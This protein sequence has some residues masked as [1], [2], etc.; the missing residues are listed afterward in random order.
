MTDCQNNVSDNLTLALMNHDITPFDRTGIP[1]LQYTLRTRKTRIAIFWAL[2]FFDSVA[3]PVLLY[4]ILWYGTDLDHSI[5]FTIITVC[6]GGTAIVEY[7]QRFWMLCKKNSTCRVFGGSR[8]TCDWFQWNMTM[9]FLIIISF[10][11]IGT[12]P[13][14]PMVRV[15]AMPLPALLAFYGLEMT[16]MELMYVF[17][18]R[19]PFRISSVARGQ[20]MRPAVYSFVEDIVAV[21][22]GGG[23]AFRLRLH[24]RYEA[25]RYFRQMLHRLSLFWAIPGMLLSVGLTFVIFTVERDLAYILGWAMPFAWTGIWAIITTKFVQRELKVEE[26]VW[27][28]ELSTRY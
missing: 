26:K 17:R 21:D 16:V 18:L 24:Q 23:T 10:L 7:F 14:E 15:L 11:T 3:I 4:F 27:Q 12:L 5:V 6:L 1:R 25:S 22:G 20:T 9:I 13:D 19:A 8:M 28:S 2:V